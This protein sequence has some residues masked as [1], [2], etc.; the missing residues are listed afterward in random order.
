MKLFVGIDVSSKDL[1]VAI[2]SSQTAQEL[3]FSGSVLNDLNGI[4]ELK[5]KILTLNQQNHYEKIVIGMESTSIYSFHPAMFFQLDDDL[6]Q[7]NLETVVLNPTEVKRFKNIF[8]E[9]KNDTIDAFYNADFLRLERYSVG[10]VKEE[11]Y[12]ALQR[13]TRSRFQL[14]ANLTESKQHFIENLYYKLNKLVVDKLDTSIFGDT[15]MNLLSDEFTN[16]D[17]N[18]IPV[19]DLAAYLNKQGHGR[20]ADPQKLA[21]AIKKA[22]RGSYRLGKVMQN[23]VDIVLSIYT[24]EIK[25]FTKLIKQLDDEITKMMTVIPEAAILQSIPGIGPVYSAG[26]IA[27]IGQIDRFDNQAKLA[28]YAGLTW[29]QYQSGNFTGQVTRMTHSGD[30]YLRYYLIEA[31]NSIIR[32]DETFNRYF[33]KKQHEVARTP[34]KRALALTARKLVRVIDKLLR[35]HQIYRKEEMV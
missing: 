25:T 26:I 16:D 22:V 28:K 17:L 13:L 10:I 27:E 8:E 35:D 31:T 14:A 33:T 7:F 15:M 21:K 19:E 9:N 24:S 32:Y 34:R 30:V 23:S 1:Q 3:L 6:N 29:K 11:Q 12:I 5:Q 2:M 18:A 20:F 4:S